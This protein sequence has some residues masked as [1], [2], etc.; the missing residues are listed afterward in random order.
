VILSF[1][2]ETAAKIFRGDS[3]ARKEAR[4]LG[5]LKVKKAYERL[6]LLNAATEKD[7]LLYPALHYHALKGSTRYSIDA[8]SR[9]SKWRITFAWADQALTDVSLVTIED[10]H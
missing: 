4:S 8:D 6:L 2:D 5:D 9:N 3:L 1:A 10:T 7:L